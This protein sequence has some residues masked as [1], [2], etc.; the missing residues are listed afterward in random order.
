MLIDLF[1]QKYYKYILLK[2]KKFSNKSGCFNVEKN[3]LPYYFRNMNNIQLLY[4][5]ENI[6]ILED[7]VFDVKINIFFRIN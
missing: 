1:V 5:L 3:D 6:M 2:A 7:A 4:E